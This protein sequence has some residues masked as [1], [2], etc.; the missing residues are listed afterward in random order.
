MCTFPDHL[1]ALEALLGRNDAIRLTGLFRRVTTNINNFPEIGYELVLNTYSFCE[2]TSAGSGVIH[3][4][5]RRTGIQ[6]GY[7]DKGST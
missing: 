4:N 2:Y 6:I 1:R 3:I 7:I 5:I